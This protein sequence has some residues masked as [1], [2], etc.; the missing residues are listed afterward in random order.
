MGVSLLS[1][2]DTYSLTPD[3]IAYEVLIIYFH[4][5]QMLP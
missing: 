3:A 5:S 1:D 4:S 2:V